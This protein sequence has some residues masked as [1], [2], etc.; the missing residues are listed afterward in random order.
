MAFC[1]RRLFY[2]LKL[3][4]PI[5]NGKLKKITYANGFSEEYVYDTL[6]RLSEIWYH[7]SDSDSECAVRYFYTTEGQLQR[8]DDLLSG[9]SR[10]YVY[11]AGG[12]ITA[13]VNNP[14]RYRSYYYDTDLNLY[15][16][17]SRYYDPAIGRF[18]NADAIG[19]ITATPMAL[20][21]KNLYA[22]CDNNPVMRVDYGGEFWGLAIAIITAVVLIVHNELQKSN[23]AV[24]SA[25][26]ADSTTTTKDKIIEH[27]PTMSNF[28][29]GLYGADHNGCEIIAVHN[30]R[31]LMGLESSFSKTADAFHNNW[32]ML[33]IS[34]FFGSNP[35]AIGRVL[36][37]YGMN[38]TRVKANEITKHG[39]YIVSFFNSNSLMIH[40][41]AVEYNDNGYTP[42]NNYGVEFDP[43]SLG[44]RY[45]CGYYLG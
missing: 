45:I 41:I 43:F 42:Y 26:D 35:Y 17:G 8:E 9:K 40:T 39:V 33:G 4:P 13:I 20:T 23:L 22:Y 1:R 32:A 16:L 28:Q 24:N 10:I 7:Y 14:F 5:L 12:S 15:Y 21:D 38:Y 34:G 30:A 44:R 27:Q 25:L 36:D 2:H 29:Y 11:N 31:L 37:S 6:D 19:V 18:I 3:K